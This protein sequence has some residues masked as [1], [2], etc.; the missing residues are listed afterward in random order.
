M[1][2]KQCRA[3]APSSSGCW[4]SH[5]STSRSR[6]LAFGNRKSWLGMS[7][8]HRQVGAW[9]IVA[10]PCER[11]DCNAMP[12]TIKKP[13]SKTARPAFIHTRSRS[14]TDRLT[15]DARIV[16][17]EAVEAG[18]DVALHLRDRAGFVA[19]VQAGVVAE[20]GRQELVLR[21]EGP[22]FHAQADVVRVVH[23]RRRRHQLVV[24]VDR[25][26]HAVLRR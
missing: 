6:G 11:G 25:D 21:T 14:G 1:M 18:G 24:L 19:H 20:V 22:R 16:G 4:C 3:I 15:S 17:E 26:H 23:Q 13:A 7:A 10:Y 2:A 5:A 8:S 9:P 12:A